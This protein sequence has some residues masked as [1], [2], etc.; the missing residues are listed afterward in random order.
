V[1]EV[2]G[3][4]LPDDEV[5]FVKMVNQGPEFAGKGTYQLR[6][7]E[8][9]MPYVKLFRHAVDVGAH[10]GMWARVLLHYF[11]KLTAF[12]PMPAHIECFFR[13]VPMDDRVMLH[14]VALGDRTGMVTLHT[15]EGSTGNTRVQNDGERTAKPYS[16]EAVVFANPGEA[17]MMRLDDCELVDTV[18]DFIKV[19]C[20]GYEY[21]VLKGGEETIKRTRPVI[22]VEQKVGKGAQY[23]ID[24]LAAC[25]L[26]ESWGMKRAH[27]ISGD[28]IYTWK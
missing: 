14:E 16:K 9:A 6:K 22:I 10:S 25:K 24:D 18:V 26:L 21:F 23:G 4:W 20:E 13:N 12:E 27:V 2:K 15:A 1:Q 11:N 5:H 7:I 8:A 28:Y 19:D 3:I 17:M